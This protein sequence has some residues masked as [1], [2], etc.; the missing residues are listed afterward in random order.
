MN[1]REIECLRHGQIKEP[2]VYPFITAN[3]YPRLNTT[4]LSHKEPEKILVG[5]SKTFLGSLILYNL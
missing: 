3:H 4:E 2:N 5:A 1:I